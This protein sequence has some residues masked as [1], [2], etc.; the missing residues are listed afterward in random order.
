MIIASFDL[1]NL[2]SHIQEL[3]KFD[4]LWLTLWFDIYWIPVLTQD[5]L[6]PMPWKLNIRN[7]CWLY[8][9]QSSRLVTTNKAHENIPFGKL[10]ER[11][12]KKNGYI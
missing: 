3:T 1:V 10:C 2:K 4:W 6:D 11:N 9:W 7:E 12:G 5:H 8:F